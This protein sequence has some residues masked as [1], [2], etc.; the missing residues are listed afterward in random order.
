MRFT[1]TLRLDGKT[2]TGLAVP[3]DV[4]AGLGG[5]R[6]IPVVVTIG[7]TTYRSTIAYRGGEAK[8]PVSAEIRAA[9]GIAAGDEVDVTVEP[10]TAP[11]AVDLP[12]DLVA[13]LAER[14]TA[15]E[16]FAALSYSTQRRHVVALTGTRAEATRAR[17]LQR[18]LDELEG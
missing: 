4:V 8:I 13:A 2:A 6:R 18:I 1:A 5:G 15:R 16:R 14:S 12:D 3:A 11:R 10:D 17:R 7:Q 9:A